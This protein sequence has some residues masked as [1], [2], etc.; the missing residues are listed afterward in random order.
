MIDFDNMGK[1]LDR[2]AHEAH[3]LVGN[4]DWDIK[5]NELTWNRV[6]FQIFKIKPKDFAGTYE[7]FLDTVH[8]EDV[9]AVKDAVDS[10]LYNAEPYCIIHRIVLP[11]KS[12]GVVMEKAD[13]F[14]N[15]NGNAVRMVGT[16]TR[17][18]DNGNSR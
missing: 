1:T 9:Q 16:V 6:T 3:R 2:L 8:E 7:G 14:F 4:W 17:I 15:A 13:V 10:A 11:D 12:I 18:E 5:G